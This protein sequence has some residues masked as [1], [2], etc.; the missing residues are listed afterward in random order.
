MLETVRGAAGVGRISSRSGLT[1]I[2]LRTS[3]S[4]YSLR[5][6][7]SSLSFTLSCLKSVCGVCGGWLVSGCVSGGVRGCEYTHLSFDSP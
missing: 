2:T 3:W 4:M 7:F 5:D 6:R 1:S